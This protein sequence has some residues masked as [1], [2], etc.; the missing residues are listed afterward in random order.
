MGEEEELA[1]VGNPADLEPAAN[2]VAADAYKLAGT[3]SKEVLIG[4]VKVLVGAVSAGAVLGLAAARDEEVER[5]W[6][7]PGGCG[8]RGRGADGEEDGVTEGGEA[9]V[10]ILAGGDV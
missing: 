9:E 2:G 5:F 10:E 6:Q 1:G 8:G 7:G 3:V 4:G